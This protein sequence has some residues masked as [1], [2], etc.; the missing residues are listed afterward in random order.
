MPLARPTPLYKEDR[1]L[2]R[3][4]PRLLRPAAEPI[5]RNPVAPRPEPVRRTGRRGQPPQPTAATPPALIAQANAAAR[6]LSL[7]SNGNRLLILSHL[8]RR[9]EMKA[10]DLV[11]AVG[12]SQSALSQHLTKLR[13]GGLVTFRREAQTLHYRIRDPQVARLVRSLQ[14]LIPKNLIPKI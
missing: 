1:A 2:A 11:H 5:A 7:M 10:G 4:S 3:S 14:G 9:R 6:V 8:A 13:N 12:L